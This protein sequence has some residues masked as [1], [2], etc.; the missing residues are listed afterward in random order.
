M[1][2]VTGNMEVPE[3]LSSKDNHIIHCPNWEIWQRRG[4]AVNIGDAE[5]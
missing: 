1:R 3:E 2:S 4:D 5:S